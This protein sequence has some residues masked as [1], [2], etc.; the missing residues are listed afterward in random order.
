MKARR[1]GS[2]RLSEL[3]TLFKVVQTDDNKKKP[4]VR[5]KK[6]GWGCLTGDKPWAG[7]ISTKT[8]N[9]AFLKAE[10]EEKWS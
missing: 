5:L 8:F 10:T 3:G 9:N 7:W 1:G 6:I 4:R 2:Y